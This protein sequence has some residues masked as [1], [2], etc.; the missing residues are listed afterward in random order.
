[1]EI[2]GKL[3]EEGEDIHHFTLCASSET[4]LKRLYLRRGRTRLLGCSA[5]RQVHQ[6]A[7]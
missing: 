7:A 2:A 6:R 3:R 1:M 4:L 5:D